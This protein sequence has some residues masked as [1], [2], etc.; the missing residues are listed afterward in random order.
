MPHASFDW[1]YPYTF[2]NP[3]S[4]L[5]FQHDSAGTE[6]GWTILTGQTNFDI[7]SFFQTY[8]CDSTPSSGVAQTTF[9]CSYTSQVVAAATTATT[10]TGFKS[11]SATSGTYF[12]VPDV[13]RTVPPDPT[14]TFSGEK[15]EFTPDVGFVYFT[16]YEIEDKGA[17][18]LANGSEQCI[19]ST[20][21]YNLTAPYAITYSGPDPRS[22]TNAAAA[23]TGKVAKKFLS[24]VGKPHA[25]PGSY[26]AL[27]TVIVVVEE[28]FSL[29]FTNLV[30]GT[31]HSASVLDTP[32]AQLP[33][34]ISASSTSDNWAS[35]LYTALTARV[36]STAQIL[37]TPS[38]TTIAKVTAPVQV[39]NFGPV[40]ESDSD[41][42]VS[43]ANDVLS[44][45]LA[46]GILQGLGVTSTSQTVSIAGTT[47]T[48]T[49]VSA[50]AVG[51]QT[52]V[53]GGAPIT[54]GRATISLD[55][56]GSSLVVDG[57][58]TQLPAGTTTFT[59]DQMQLTSTKAA[60]FDIA[61]QTLAAG[62]AEVTVD[63]TKLSLVTG[64]NA[65]IAGTSTMMLSPPPVITVNAQTV[66]ADASS[67]F[68]F[69]AGETLTRG[70]SVIIGGTTVSLVQAGTA[71]VVNG[72][73]TTVG[74]ATAGSGQTTSGP[75]LVLDGQT[76]SPAGAGGYIIAGQT[77]LAGGTI[78]FAGNNG[79]ETVALD[80]SG[81]VVVDV[82]SGKS[83]TSTLSVYAPPI[84]LGSQTFS[85]LSGGGATYVINGQTLTPGAV[86]T[87]T[88]GGSTYVVTL[89]NV[90]TAVVIQT[91][92]NGRP[93]ATSTEML[94]T[95][96][97]SAV[98]VASKTS[99]AASTAAATS[100][101][102]TGKASSTM[103]EMLTALCG[104]LA[105]AAAAFL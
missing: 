54:V 79:L 51:G 92:S 40:P 30:A 41:S 44:Q 53:A 76:Y 99:L 18:T 17:I 90:P 26:T 48:Q 16:E 70:G 93:V 104:A 10:V 1:W 29:Q 37:L 13:R 24:H 78:T 71:I 73:T 59:V 94:I 20:S 36:E 86:R 89:L 61:G 4:A 25:T 88:A 96:A 100:A 52:A 11:P 60:A 55:S 77:L 66:T 57:Q 74:T 56:S 2:Y 32:T 42:S 91:L 5:S 69:G 14:V 81:T 34:G 8:V 68:I 72:Q 67:D 75:T 97:T 85:A 39:N 98:V 102:A 27:P 64:G 3:V 101:P 49:S 84:T 31:M 65:I 45:A 12:D 46:P 43:D 103:P 23:V 63:G 105:L 80:R 62:G 6:T 87:V 35:I 7:A 21:T 47:G 19:T 82:V 15:A 83:T 22:A 9:D 28:I 50:V 95:S 38:A 33:S 58:T